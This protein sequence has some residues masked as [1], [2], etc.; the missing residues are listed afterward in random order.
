MST[1]K[2]VMILN[3]MTN[4]VIVLCVS[5]LYYIT[6]TWHPFVLLFFISFPRRVS[7]ADND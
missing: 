4:I 3:M 6:R 5:Y 2:L 1:T 7:E